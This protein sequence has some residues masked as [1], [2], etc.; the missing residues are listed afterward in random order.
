LMIRF[1][2]LSGGVM[3]ETIWESFQ[4]TRICTEQSIR[5]DSLYVVCT[6]CVRV[7]NSNR[8]TYVFDRRTQW[9]PDAWK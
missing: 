2:S 8:H 1:M 7:V 9:N 3:V 5:S 6:V 4:E